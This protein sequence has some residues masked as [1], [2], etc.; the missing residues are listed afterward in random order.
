MGI[1]NCGQGGHGGA[2]LEIDSHANM[3]DTG[4]Q[5]YV[6]NESGLHANVRAFSDEESGM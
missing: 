4:E 3:I 6:F 1:T 5:A 2:G